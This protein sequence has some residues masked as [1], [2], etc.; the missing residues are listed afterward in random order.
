M[1]KL[2]RRIALAKRVGESWGM[3]LLGTKRCKIVQLGHGK[4]L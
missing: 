3:Q 2:S 1:T 4:T